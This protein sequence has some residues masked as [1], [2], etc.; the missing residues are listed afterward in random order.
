MASIK[1]LLC[2]TGGNCVVNK[3]A[4]CFTGGNCGVNEGAV[5]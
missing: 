4:S 2:S 3:W 1:G 5:V